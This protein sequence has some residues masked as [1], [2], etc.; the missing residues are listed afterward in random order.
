[1]LIYYHIDFSITLRYANSL[2]QQSITLS[3]C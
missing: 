2:M 1:M 3:G